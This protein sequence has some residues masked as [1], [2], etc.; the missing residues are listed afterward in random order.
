MGG[1][2]WSLQ[3]WTRWSSLPPW[4]G[5]IWAKT[6]E[7]EDV[8]ERYWIAWAGVEVGGQGVK[9]WRERLLPGPNI[10]PT[11]G[12][13][14]CQR[15]QCLCSLC[16]LWTSWQGPF[17]PPPHHCHTGSLPVSSSLI[18]NKAD[19]LALLWSRIAMYG[20]AGWILYRMTH[21]RGFR[22]HFRHSKFVY[23]D[24][25]LAGGSKVFRWKQYI[26]VLLWQLGYSI[27]KKGN[28]F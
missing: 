21:L 1:V 13:K 14:W 26:A 8:P 6:K 16:F 25:F 24:T 15:R 2:G 19:G 22:L 27:L 9:A 7:D 5:D 12:A 3:F 11:L 4:E 18:V 20:C 17:L 28:V 10:R 23:Y